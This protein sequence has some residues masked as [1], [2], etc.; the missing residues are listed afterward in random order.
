MKDLLRTALLA[1]TLIGGSAPSVYAEPS[2]A[3]KFRQAALMNQMNINASKHNRGR[4][5]DDWKHY[6]NGYQAGYNNGYHNGW[7]KNWKHGGWN[8]NKHNWDDQRDYLHNN[9]MARRNNLSA[10]QRR[11][12][13]AQLRAQ[14][15][16]Y[17]NNSWNGG[18][19]WNM[20]NDPAFFDYMHTNNPSFVNKLR[21]WL[22]F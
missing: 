20:Y 17:H 21:G 9:W 2:N 13:D 6:N 16:A 19:N 10:S 8:W 7:N 22:G 15:L 5:H 4:H 14:W 12:L 18:Y 1:L 3:E 11:A